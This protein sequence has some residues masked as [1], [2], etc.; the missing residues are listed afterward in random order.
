MT[1]LLELTRVYY[2]KSKVAKRKEQQVH[3]NEQ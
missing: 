1:D 2:N 3:E